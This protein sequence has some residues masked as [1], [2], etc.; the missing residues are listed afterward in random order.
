MTAFLT[1]L[2]LGTVGLAGCGGNGDNA[3]AGSDDQVT[4][5]FSWW[6]SA[7]K[8]DVTFITAFEDQNPDIN[9][10]LVNFGQDDYSQKINSMIVGGTAPDVILAWEVDLPRFAENDAI[11]SLDS[12]IDDSDEIGGLDDFIPAVAELSEMTDGT[13]GLPW[14]YAGHLLYFNKDM[15]DAVGVD[16]PTEDW[17]WEDFENA[18]KELTIVDGNTTTQWGADAI[19][20]PGIWYSMAGSA[21]DEIVDA[22]LNLALGD[23]LR[24]TLEFQD[25][26]TNELQVSPQPSVG[27]EVADLFLAGRAAMTRH[28]SWM[29]GAYRDADFNW[30][31][32]P[33]PTDER[34]YTS[35]HTGFFTI[36]SQS[37]HQEEAWRFIEFMMSQEGQTLISEFT[38]NPSAIM[39][40]AKEGAFKVAGEN[41]PSNW[42]AFNTIAET[43]KFNY[44]LLNATVTNNLVNE[45]NSVLMGQQTID[46]VIGVEVPRAQS[47]LE[48]N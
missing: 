45:F 38:G 18:A 34:E 12:F 42:S 23:G 44:V 30:D 37:E 16:H 47:R 31:M 39:S 25:R 48:E 21:G 14:A 10:E 33:L 13:Y 3:N 36:N 27:G 41:G 28:G 35:L 40:V 32:V 24:R 46:D 1:A 22:D 20:F 19:S 5:R 6:D 43:G 9:V 15:F 8:E 2:T 4:I 7:N 26:L 29:I 17:T 11:I